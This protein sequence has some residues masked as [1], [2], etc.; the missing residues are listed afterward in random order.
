[1]EAARRYYAFDLLP[2]FWTALIDHA[3]DKRVLSIDR[4]KGEIERGKDDL[5]DWVKAEFSFAF[6]STDRPDV[7]LEFGVLMRWVY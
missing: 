4:V 7:A 6:A 5:A 3:K 1:M 2:Q